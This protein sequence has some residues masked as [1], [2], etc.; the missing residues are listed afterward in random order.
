[1]SPRPPR[2]DWHKQDAEADE[3]R[4]NKCRKVELQ[5]R[6]NETGR[7][8]RKKEREKHFRAKKKREIHLKNEET[9]GG[10]GN[11][12]SLS[13]LLAAADVYQSPAVGVDLTT[14]I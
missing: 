9:E 4:K 11:L 1:M 5:R 7:K 3:R 14:A 13:V 6:E 8:E 2:P 10:S 12:E